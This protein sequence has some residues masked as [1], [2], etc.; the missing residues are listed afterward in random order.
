MNLLQSYLQ[1]H[2]YFVIPDIKNKTIG[3]LDSAFQERNQCISHAIQM[4]SWN[5]LNM[6]WLAY[7]TWLM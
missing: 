1:D 2:L 4:V 6:N 3:I 7:L 5:I